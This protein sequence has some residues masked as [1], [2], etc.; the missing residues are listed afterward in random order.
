MLWGCEW[1]WCG[2]VRT[3]LYYVGGGVGGRMYVLVGGV[4]CEVV[5]GKF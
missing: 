3:K 1:V 4:R 5:D 2:V